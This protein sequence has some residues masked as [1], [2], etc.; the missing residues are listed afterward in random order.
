MSSGKSVSSSLKKL[1]AG[2][3]FDFN[4]DRRD[5]TDLVLQNMACL[6]K[7]KSTKS[8]GMD[9]RRKMSEKE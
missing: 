3:F 7:H 5:P 2:E 8:Y 4:E 9:L 6:Y 1:P